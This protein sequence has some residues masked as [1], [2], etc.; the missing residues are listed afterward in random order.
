MHQ[1]KSRVKKEPE[2][3][4][5]VAAEGKAYTEMLD[6]LIKENTTP[7]N[8][9]TNTKESRPTGILSTVE[10]RNIADWAIRNDVPASQMGRIIQTAYESMKADH[11]KN[12]DRKHKNVEKFLDGA[13]IPAMVGNPSLFNVPGTDSPSDLREIS[14]LSDTLVAKAKADGLGGIQGK[15]DNEIKDHIYKQFA[16]DFTTGSSYEVPDPSTGGKKTVTLTE[17]MMKGFIEEAKK[18]N[19]SPFQL[20]IKQRL[21]QPTLIK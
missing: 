10:G 1:D 15:S 17:G 5:R 18:S 21:R 4:A 7:A 3:E 2:Y 8:A 11:A 6:Q 14:K 20:F 12:P 9:K 16:R 19:T 13:Y